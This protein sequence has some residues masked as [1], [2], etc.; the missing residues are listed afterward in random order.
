MQQPSS[1]ALCRIIKLHYILYFEFFS[2]LVLE[3]EIGFGRN[4]ILEICANFDFDARSSKEWFVGE[5][6]AHSC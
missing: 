2:Y 6:K 5:P 1:G 3:S 4:D